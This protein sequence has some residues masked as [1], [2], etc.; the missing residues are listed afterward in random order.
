[1]T[2][3]SMLSAA[4]LSARPV[5]IALA[6]MIGVFTFGVPA[7]A[8]YGGLPAGNWSQYCGNA[9]MNGNE[10]QAMCRRSNGRMEYAEANI[11][12]CG[13]IVSYNPYD[14]KLHCGYGGNPPSNMMSDGLPGGN[15]R[16][17]CNQGRMQGS[18]LKAF[19]RWSDGQVRHTE[20]NISD[21]PRGVVNFDPNGGRFY[22]G[23]GQGYPQGGYP[24]GGYPPGGPTDRGY[25]PSGSWSQSCT[26][27]SMQGSIL[28]AQCRNNFGQ[29]VYS[30]IDT[31]QC[32]NAGVRNSNGQ[33][34]C[35]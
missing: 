4:G 21:C 22:C 20:A 27:A 28:R 34:S 17:F 13:G 32:Y 16:Q 18:E 26:N 10:L 8:Q 2:G 12:R 25:F 7:Q 5:L 15:W 33:L 30:Q 3:V 29:L 6:A 14:G 24:P 35:Q 11:E 23:G 19:C 1:M 9:R 31:S